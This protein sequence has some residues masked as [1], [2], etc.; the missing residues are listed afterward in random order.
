MRY[1]LHSSE[2][3]LHTLVWS[4]SGVGGLQNFQYQKA[5]SAREESLSEVLGPIRKEENSVI[6]VNDVYNILI[7]S[8]PRSQSACAKCPSASHKV[9]KICTAQLLGKR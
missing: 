8:R 4:N 5:V 3:R 9:R 2:S 1:N 7:V 6:I